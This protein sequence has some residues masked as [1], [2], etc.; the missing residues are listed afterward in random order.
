MKKQKVDN[1]LSQVCVVLGTQWGDEGKGKIVDILMQEYDV[2]GRFNGGSN[3]GHTIIVEGVKYAFHLLPSGILN[4]KAECLIGNG[5]VVHLPTLVTELEKLD[6]S[7]IAWKERFFISDR[8]HLVFDIHQKMDGAQETELSTGK[9][10]TTGRGIGPTYCEKMNR[11]GVRACDLADFQLVETKYRRIVAHAVRLFPILEEFSQE[12]NIQKELKRYKEYAELFKA[13]IV[14]GVYWINLRYSQNKKIMMEGAN[15]A[16]L[17]ID[18][19]TYPF[20]TSSNASI[21]GCLTGLGLST[22]KVGDVIGVVKAYTTRV[23]EGPFPTELKGDLG[24]KLRTIGGEFGTTTGRPRRCGWFDAVV[25]QYTALLNGY[26]HLNLTKLDCLRGFSELKIGVAYVYGGTKLPP[27]SMP[28]DLKILSNV[29][30]EYETLPG[31]EEDISKCKKFE[32]LPENA[33]K[34]ILRIEKLVGV[35]IRWIGVGADR[36]A[37]AEK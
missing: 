8:A 37:V 18:F 15:A 31:F 20:V 16:M 28:A 25:V 23:G 11:T 3:A 6:K 27:G 36:D 10:G 4:P 29:K 22:N 14:D 5:C 13:N 19:G 24:D 9:L 12:A 7:K 33:Q 34:Y 26:T 35:P 17:D 2:C 21:G 1:S 30:V 32:E